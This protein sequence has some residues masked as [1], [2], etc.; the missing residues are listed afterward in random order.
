MKNLYHI[1]S[2]KKHIISYIRY[3]IETVLLVFS[4]MMR[5][6]PQRP[7]M[8]ARF[9]LLAP[10][11][12]GGTAKTSQLL[13]TSPNKKTSSGLL[14]FDVVVSCWTYCW[15]YCCSIVVLSC[16][17]FPPD[18]SPL[19]IFAFRLSAGLASIVSWDNRAENGWTGRPFVVGPPTC[20]NENYVTDLIA[21]NSKASRKIDNW[22]LYIWEV[23]SIIFFS[24][25]LMFSTY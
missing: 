13:R 17:V 25:P 23:F 4:Q 22:L 6:L 1:T 11:F 19:S 9:Q 3:C 18:P 15:T 10:R 14:F 20:R 21:V 24:Y 8:P 7:L 16:Y 5:Y 12:G 2:Y